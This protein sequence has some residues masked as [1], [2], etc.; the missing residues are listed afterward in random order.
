MK[1]V[2]SCRPDGSPPEG[3][4]VAGDLLVLAKYVV[5]RLFKYITL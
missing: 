4:A 2:I 5:I 1:L 3:R